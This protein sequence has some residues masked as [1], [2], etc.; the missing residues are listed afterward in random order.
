MGGNDLGTDTGSTAINLGL[1]VAE[2]I[3]QALLKLLDKIWQTWK[4]A[5]NRKLQKAKISE[6]SDTQKKLKV[7]KSMNGIKGEIEWNKLKKLSDAKD[8]KIVATGIRFNSEEDIKR[9][10]ELA[11]RSGIVWTGVNDASKNL[12]EQTTHIHCLSSDVA[13]IKDIC[14]LIADENRVKAIESKIEEIKDKDTLTDVDKAN[15]ENLEKTKKAIIDKY[16]GQFNEQSFKDIIEDTLSEKNINKTLDNENSHSENKTL[17]DESVSY[18]TIAQEDTEKES[19]LARAFDMDTS[20]TFDRGRMYV[21]ADASE[22]NRFIVCNSDK[23]TFHDKEYTKTKYEVHSPDGKVNTFDDGRFEGRE[24]DHWYNLKKEMQE[25]GGFEYKA[26]LLKF[27]NYQDFQKWQA[28]T[29]RENI[30][31]K[32][33]RDLTT[34]YDTHIETNLS[35]IKKLGFEVREDGELYSTKYDRKASDLIADK[36][37]LSTDDPKIKLEMLNITE[38]TVLKRQLDTLKELKGLEEKIGITNAELIT[39]DSE[40][41]RKEAE[42]KL[43]PLEEKKE[44]LTNSAIKDDDTRS[45][46]NGL[47]NEAR[48]AMRQREKTGQAYEQSDKDWDEKEFANDDKTYG[49]EEPTGKGKDGIERGQDGVEQELEEENTQTMSEYEQEISEEKH[50]DVDTKSMDGKNN[51]KEEKS[52]P[53]SHDR[54]D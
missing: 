53:K 45:R 30:A 47:E 6:Y 42:A 3:L 31:E 18:Q 12:G 46:L 19:T 28:R 7:L 15:I 16:T 24:K 32:T 35:E 43:K 40:E 21:I 44:A 23:D 52:K 49:K 38:A 1:K 20:R 2:N 10:A 17:E 39:A 29:I 34:Q 8:V 22:P 5:P 9:F 54:A 48:E 51:G 37:L 13:T 27:D 26:T 41:A 25:V 33:K 11:K 14:N 4:E 50:K 36:R